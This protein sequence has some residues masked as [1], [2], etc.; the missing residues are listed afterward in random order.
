MNSLPDPLKQPHL[1]NRLRQ[2]AIAAQQQPKRSVA[3]QRALAKLIGTILQSQ[4]LCRPRIGQ[5]RGLYED[6]YAE[7]LQ[8][9]FTFVCEHIDDYST[10]RGEVLQ[11]INFLLSQRFFVE[12]SKDHFP[13]VYKR[14]DARDVKRLTLEQ[15]DQ[16]NPVDLNPR[17]APLLSEKVKNCL[18]E[19]P[20]GLFQ[21]AHV[22]DNPAANFQHLA[23]RRI[24]GYSW[25][26]LSAE[27]DI[28]V[29]TLSSFYR[30][31]LARFA[32]KLEECL[33]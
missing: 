10:Q 5:F 18:K 22:T 21:R 11:W 8:H 1:D 30:R 6:I 31:C 13:T 7:A 20:E 17:L 19:D 33:S 16:N 25:K 3:R 23:I 12:A 32:S 24:E 4:K 2:L 15:L 27:L 29:P 26:D 28:P 14:I 9:L